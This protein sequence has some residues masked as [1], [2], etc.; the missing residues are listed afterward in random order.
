MP[1]ALRNVCK[2]LQGPF[3]VFPDQRRRPRQAE[4]LLED[5]RLQVLWRKQ[6]V[7]FGRSQSSDHAFVPVLQ[8]LGSGNFCG[9]LPADPISFPV[10]LCKKERRYFGWFSVMC[11]SVAQLSSSAR[12]G[13]T[14]QV[15]NWNFNSGVYG[16][17]C[18]D[19]GTQDRQRHA[20]QRKVQ[21]GREMAC[22]SSTEGGKCR[23]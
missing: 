18:H 22:D 9:K 12:G 15:R 7:S 19:P 6:T 2:R 14:W 21:I 5:K 3:V 16:K 13:R 11:S 8:D 10:Q 1:R 23:A 20:P 4:A 17:E